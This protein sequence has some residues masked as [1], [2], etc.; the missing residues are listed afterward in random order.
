MLAIQCGVRPLLFL[1]YERRLNGRYDD[2]ATSNV[3]LPHPA[4]RELMPVYVHSFRL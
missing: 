1:E 4:R 2:L 3:P